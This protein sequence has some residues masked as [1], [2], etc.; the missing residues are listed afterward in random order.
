MTV[1]R[2][3]ALVVLVAACGNAAPDAQPSQL[4]AKS[5]A[6]PRVAAPP[7]TKPARAPE[8]RPQKLASGAHGQ[9]ITSVAVAEDGK[10]AVTI[11]TSNRVRLWP[12]LDASRDP[13]VVPMAAPARVAIQRDGDTFVLGSL[14]AAGG[15]AIQRIDSTGTLVDQV[16]FEPAYDDLVA[17]SDGFFAIRGDQSIVRF[18]AR[19]KQT[20]AVRPEP[21]QRVTALVH[22]RGKTLALLASKDGVHGRWV[23]DTFPTQPWG[24]E[25]PALP[26]A[27]TTAAL[28]PDHQHLAAV[29]AKSKHPVVVELA[30]GRATELWNHSWDDTSK[31]IPLGFVANNRI[32]LQRTDFE[33]STI[34]WWDEHGNQ[35]SEIGNDFELEFVSVRDS[36]VGDDRVLAFLDLELVLVAPASVRYLGYRIPTASRLHPTP[37]GMVAGIG[38]VPTLLD[39][40][41][42]ATKRLAIPNLAP[43]GWADIYPLADTRAIVMSHGIEARFGE[44]W[45]DDTL[46]PPRKRAPRFELVDLEARKKLQTLPF[47]A[48]DHRINFEP[49]TQLLGVKAG[50]SVLLA[51]L[52]TSFDSPTTVAIGTPIRELALLDPALAGGAVALAAATERGGIKLWRIGTEDL[53]PGSTVRAAAPRTYAGTLEAID[54]AGNVYMRE[55]A[56]VVVIHA[57]DRELARL[58]DIAGWKL[59]PSPDATRVAAFGRG[60]IVL[61]KLDGAEIWAVAAPG[62]TDL[63]WTPDGELAVHARG[64]AKLDPLD[65][66]PLAARCGWGL[67]IRSA[68]PTELTTASSLCDP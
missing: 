53:S 55:S 34:S 12:A 58:G 14:D 33:L 63:Q 62:V 28:S 32:V 67:A 4:A 26:I 6:I 2:R 42:R 27:P 35:K 5:P 64:L 29:S 10:S 24:E 13:W 19:G 37:G 11:D 46:V 43:R 56:D 41:F 65:G 31:A 20:A 45:L 16:A 18:D 66:H 59:R 1:P 22:R 44:E 7:V 36:A 48:R 40:D 3:F 15:L 38:G 8:F 49:T 61:R 54:R 68:A 9:P 52:T 21:G 50:S 60:R 23:A 30:T 57:R 17:A 47:A 51:H 39:D 25:T